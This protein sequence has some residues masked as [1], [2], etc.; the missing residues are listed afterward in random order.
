M[1]TITVRGS[2]SESDWGIGQDEAGFTAMTSISL[3]ERTEK[4]EGKNSRGCVVAIAYYN[5]TSE[6]SIEGLGD[7]KK[8]AGES[9]SVSSVSPDNGNLYVDES[10]VE[11][12]N[13][14]WVKT[15]IKATGYEN[16]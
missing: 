3:T 4:A 9:L 8:S 13:E 7:N 6:V 15:T 14:D 2:F 10:T 11:F 12:S 16:I 1:C 5:K